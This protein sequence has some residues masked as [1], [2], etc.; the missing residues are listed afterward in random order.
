MRITWICGFVAMGIQ[1]LYL[2]LGSASHRTE[3]FTVL[4][5]WPAV[6]CLRFF[7][8]SKV[9]A[10]TGHQKQKYMLAIKEFWIFQ[11]EFNLSPFSSQLCGSH[12]LKI[13]I[14]F[15]STHVQKLCW[16]LFSPVRIIVEMD[17]LL[18]RLSPGPVRPPLE[19]ALVVEKIYSWL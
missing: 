13:W 18:V 15:W 12:S 8:K 17:A 9:N 4:W 11:L 3:Y 2:K 5:W 6:G 16:W 10:P 19:F 7:W 14:E 1:K